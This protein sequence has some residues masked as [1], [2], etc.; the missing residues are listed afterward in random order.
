MSRSSVSSPVS[1][2]A[3]SNLA[4]LARLKGS[5]HKQLPLIKSGHLA[6]LIAAGFGQKTHASLLALL[7]QPQTS[8]ATLPV[9]EEAFVQRAHELG[10]ADQLHYADLRLAYQKAVAAVVQFV[11]EKSTH[12]PYLTSSSLERCH[13]Y[14]VVMRRK[15]DGSIFATHPVAGVLGPHATLEMAAADAVAQWLS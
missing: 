1:D 3:T 8:F 13:A 15:A 12:E 4:A 11:Y 9:H 14:G 10:Y 6:E 5:L 2:T 7:Q